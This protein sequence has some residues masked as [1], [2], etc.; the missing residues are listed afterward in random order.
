M[1]V[2]TDVQRLQFEVRA[3]YDAHRGFPQTP[4]NGWTTAPVTGLDFYPSPG[5]QFAL[6]R[7]GDGQ[8]VYAI[9][10]PIAP[11]SR[12]CYR[13]MGG[14]DTGVGIQCVGY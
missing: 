7:S 1:T 4:G 11:P 2:N 3:Y 14:Y 13:A 5:M 9:I 8:S 12:Y 10:G 6:Q